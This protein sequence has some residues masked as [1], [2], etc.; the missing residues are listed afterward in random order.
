MIDPRA[1]P[2]TIMRL[3]P[4]SIAERAGLQAG[5][6]V[7]EINGVAAETMLMGDMAKAF[8]GSPVKLRIERGGESLAITM[9]FDDA[10]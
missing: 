5:D 2:M 8:R 9:S 6:I 1:K 10:S 3:Q 7:R 4:G